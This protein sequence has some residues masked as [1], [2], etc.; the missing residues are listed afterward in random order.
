MQWPDSTSG[1]VCREIMHR[2]SDLIVLE[3]FKVDLVS[4]PP[5]RSESMHQ[6]APLEVETHSGIVVEEA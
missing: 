1:V 2:I 6:G 3:S 4:G 5:I